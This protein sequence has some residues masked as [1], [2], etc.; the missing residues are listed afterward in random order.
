MMN[1]SARQIS[2]SD[3]EYILQNTLPLWQQ[4]NSKNILITGG[5]GFFGKWLLESFIYISQK[6]SLSTHVYVLSRDPQ[7]FIAQYPY[8]IH[9]NI[10]FISGDICEFVFPDVPLHY[11]IHAATEASVSLNLEQPLLMYDTIVDGTRH[12]LELARSKNVEAVLHTSSGAVY[13]QQ[14]SDITHISESDKLCPD[15]YAKNAAYGEGK[16]VAEML[17]SFY[18]HQY[19]IRSKIARCFAFVGPYLP[20]DGY[21]AI[22]NFIND[23]L[24]G[25]PISINGD[26]TPY[27]SYMYASDL[28]IWL[29]TLLLKG[30][31]CK[32]YNVGSDEDLTIA[33]LAQLVVEIGDQ[34]NDIAI[35]VKPDPNKQPQRYVPSVNL[36]KNEL[37]LKVKVSIQDSI[38]KTMDFYLT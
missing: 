28:I 24:N 36:A 33:R 9:Q 21:F 35:A 19:G 23:T 22:G 18:Y 13:G 1:K 17:S 12:V 26:G 29:L 25:R 38:R 34:G 5:T 20:L 16:R 30:E 4:L 11:I 2:D 8:Y 27:R 15:I 37:N 3:L 14:P 31:P 10:S 7:S 6:L 32:P